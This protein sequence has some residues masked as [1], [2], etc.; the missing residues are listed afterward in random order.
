[1]MYHPNHHAV[2]EN[3]LSSY[4][5]QGGEV[6]GILFISC[7]V[8]IKIKNVLIIDHT[9]F[10]DLQRGVKFSL[11]R[12]I[13]THQNN[14]HPYSPY[15]LPLEIVKLARKEYLLYYVEI[16][17]SKLSTNLGYFQTPHFSWKTS[18]FGRYIVLSPEDLK[19]TS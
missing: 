13:F 15:I 2:E 18:S 8:P 6:S 10:P 5:A 7:L 3:M 4:W 19:Q 11:E 1:M 17:N 16:F 12:P 9:I 14:F